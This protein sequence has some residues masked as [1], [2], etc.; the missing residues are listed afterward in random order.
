MKRELSLIEH[1][2]NGILIKRML[3]ALEELKKYDPNQPR[4][5]RGSSNGGQWV[6]N[7][8]GSGSSAGEA[9]EEGHKPHRVEQIKPR[10]EPRVGPG[11]ATI[12][13]IDWSEEGLEHFLEGADAVADILDKIPLP[14]AKPAAAA[15]RVPGKVRWMFGRHKSVVKWENRMRKGEWTKR[16][17]TATIA[18]GKTYDAP[19]K[20]NPGNGATR[21]QLGDRYVVKDNKTGEII[22]I[23]RPGIKPEIE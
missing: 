7:G 19:N 16:N 4:A 10:K 18:K 1:E 11:A 5:P 2:Y 23:S 6:S 8:G 12:P 20:V 17:I 13:D 15:L 22:Q 14:D 21:Y 3:D 9:H